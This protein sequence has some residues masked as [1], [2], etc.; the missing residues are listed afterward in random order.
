MAETS[1]AQGTLK[2]LIEAE[3]QAREIL[4]AAQAQA[5]ETV[6]QAREQARQS[7][8]ATRAEAANLLRAKLGEAE[9]EGAAEMKQ[10]LQQADD[11]SREFERRA[12]ENFAQAVEMAVNWVVSGEEL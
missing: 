12:E 8:E 7:V 5:D 1:S 3:E 4:K 2:R 6:S 11:R 9:S 10:R